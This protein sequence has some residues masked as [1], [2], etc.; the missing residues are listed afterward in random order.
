MA[1]WPSA[2]E[3]HMYVLVLF[4]PGE[5]LCKR[6]M[7]NYDSKIT[8]IFVFRCKARVEGGAVGTGVV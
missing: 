2:V 3:L 5:P 7:K 8:G 6:K 1:A 4:R